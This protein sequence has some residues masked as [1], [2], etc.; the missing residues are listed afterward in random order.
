MDASQEHRMLNPVYSLGR[1][2]L[3]ERIGY[4]TPHEQRRM[5]SGH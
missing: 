4:Q 1:G 3:L 5:V 2:A